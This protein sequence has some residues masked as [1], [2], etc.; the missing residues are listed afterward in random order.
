MTPNFITFISQITAF[1]DED[2]KLAAPLFVTRQLKRG[3]FWI[4]EGEFKDDLLF[5]NKGLM[6]AFFMKNDIEKTFDL[7][8]ENQVFTSANCYSLGVPSRDYIQA[9]EDTHFISI[10]K[11]N[12]EVIFAHSPKWERTGRIIAEFYTVE[13]EDRIRSFIVDTAQERYEN[14][15][16]NRPELIQRTPQIYLAN[17]LGITPQSLS[18][19]RRNMVT[20]HG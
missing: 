5:V 8:S 18:R 17:Y 12:L 10:S 15:A 7:V 6:R 13:Q 4:K 1:T 3:E 9:V 16:K 19:L 14:L 2:I 20:N 11:E